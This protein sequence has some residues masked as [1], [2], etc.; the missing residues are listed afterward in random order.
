MLSDTISATVRLTGTGFVLKAVFGDGCAI[1]EEGWPLYP[2]PEPRLRSMRAL[3]V[4]A[5][6]DLESWH[7]RAMGEFDE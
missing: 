1:E 3:S 7:A 6:I 2:A 5:Q 4:R